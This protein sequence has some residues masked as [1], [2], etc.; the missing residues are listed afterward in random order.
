[1]TYFAYIY[2]QRENK[3]YTVTFYKLCLAFDRQKQ[4]RKC[5]FSFCSLREFVGNWYYFFPRCLGEL[6]NTVVWVLTYFY[7]KVFS[8]E[9][10]FGY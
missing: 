5:L 7:G 4:I 8:E 9:L 1:M 2:G 10:N 6:N 3:I